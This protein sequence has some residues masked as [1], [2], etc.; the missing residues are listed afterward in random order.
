MAMEDDLEE[1]AIF[2]QTGERLAEKYKPSDSHDLNAPISDLTFM[3]LFTSWRGRALKF[4]HLQTG[5]NSEYAQAF[6]RNCSA[7]GS[8]GDIIAGLTELERVKQGI[9]GGLFER[10]GLGLFF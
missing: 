6:S 7:A 1:V 8:Y 3:S 10:K 5:A 2:I 4:V 9:M